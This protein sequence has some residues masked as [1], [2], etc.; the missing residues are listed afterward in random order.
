[1]KSIFAF[2]AASDR[3]VN[4]PNFRPALSKSGPRLRFV[5][6][7]AAELPRNG[8][9][10]ALVSDVRVAPRVL[11]SLSAWARDQHD[12]NAEIAG[13]LFGTV[14]EGVV[15][16]EGLTRVSLPKP[17]LNG[18][19]IGERLEKAFDESM[20]DSKLPRELAS[21]RLIGWW[22]VRPVQ[23]LRR[24]RK[25]LEFHNQRFRRAT[26][27]FAVVTVRQTR[28]A[29]AR[30]FARSRHLPLSSKHHRSAWLDL[31]S[32]ILPGNRLV[33]MPAG[34][35]HPDLC[36]VAYRTP[37]GLSRAVQFRKQIAGSLLP[38]FL[39]RSANQPALPPAAATGARKIR[40]LMPAAFLLVA[41]AVVLALVISN[42]A[43]LTP[44][45][46][47]PIPP[48]R[49]NA[50]FRMQIESQNDG[51]LIGWNHNLPAV[52][53]ATRGVLQIEDGPQIHTTELGSTELAKGSIVYKPISA[54]VNF[55][56][57]MYGHDGST[58]TDR[59]R[60]VDRSKQVETADASVSSHAK[61]AAPAQT[62]ADT[63]H[64]NSLPSDFA[65]TISVPAARP[66]TVQMPSEAPVIAPSVDPEENRLPS[67]LGTPKPAA[68]E[69]KPAPVESTPAS[70]T[71]SPVS[72][73]ASGRSNAANASSPQLRAPAPSAGNPVPAPMPPRYIPPRPL[74][75]I[76]PNL[77]I[78]G[79]S[80]LAGIREIQIEV[81]VDTSGHVTAARAVNKS[82]NVSW[83]VAAAVIA[84]AKKWTFEPAKLDGRVV[85]AKHTI[86]FHVA[87]S[88]LSG[89]PPSP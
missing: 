83:V 20:S 5:K 77:A 12:S 26:D 50:L 48:A 70:A 3:P 7:V 19:G 60:F 47:H 71:T 52:R 53:S 51:V 6:S 41:L 11:Q 46:R 30:L 1:M 61:P 65:D 29:S 28:A 24:L 35:L 34:H 72:P 79:G 55:R 85:P 33:M 73:A 87:G 78:F 68:F 40:F 9:P 62:S 8:R 64:T 17:V 36:L 88:G 56:L 69:P 38:P 27:V 45:E 76:T 81:D 82:Q 25:E 75:T 66:K 59:V 80:Q 89:P 14:A 49:S 18:P 21:Q 15:S 16:V 32:Q 22:C 10:E 86:V 74:T 2:A 43:S 4:T 44:V 39:K 84:A 13:L 54:D 31:P 67:D 63:E 57:T 37:N 23:K 58:L 42:N